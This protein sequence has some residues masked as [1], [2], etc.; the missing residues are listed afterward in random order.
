MPR[1]PAVDP[2]TATGRT[3]EIFEGPLK[4]KHFNIFKAMANSPAAL[5]AY[6]GLAGA[7]GNANLSAKEQEVIHL[8]IGNA[9]NC[10]YCQA[11]HTAIGKMVGLTDE[12]T[13]AARRGTIDDDAKLNALAAFAL[14]IHEKRGFID[15]EDLAA[16]KSAG[17]TDAHVPEVLATYALATYTNFFNHVAETE[18]DFPVVAGV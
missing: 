12:Q 4:G 2:A 9:N 11:A 7:L 1:L 10:D 5:D 8:A 3:K 16:F 15:D 6:L 18:I 14:A 17:Y 13:V